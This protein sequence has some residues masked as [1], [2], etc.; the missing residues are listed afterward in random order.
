M[1]KA[2]NLAGVRVL[3]TG[4]TGFSGVWLTTLLDQLGAEVRGYSRDDTS[5]STLFP[6]GTIGKKWNSTFGDVLDL[7]RLSE[8]LSSFRPDIVFHLAAQSLVKEG[9]ARPLETFRTNAL[10]TAT[11]LEA[12]LAQDGLMGVVVITTDKVYE[13]GAQ[14]KTEGSNLLGRDPYSSSKVCAEHVVLGYR[15]HFKEAGVTLTVARGGNI[16]GGG[17]WAKNRIIPDL[18]RA[19]LHSKPLLLRYPKASR[20]WQ[21]VLD[22]VN[23]Y[24]SIGSEI[25]SGQGAL[26]STEFNVGP[27]PSQERTVWDLVEEFGSYGFI[28]ETQFEEPGVHEADRLQISSQRSKDLLGWAPGLDF[29][30]SVQLTAEWYRLICMD[31]AD[32]Y[33]T[34]RRQVMDF[35]RGYGA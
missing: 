25:V 18:V 7:P 34:T 30:A 21:H 8:E 11:V 17:D 13:E 28:V 24:A 23:C 22:L 2:E 35:L 15:Q 19:S 33:E 29:G 14:V 27:D 6:E 1:N 5:F 31:S 32:A 12:C 4:H 3:V 26:V 16:I 20:P 9:Y 10:G